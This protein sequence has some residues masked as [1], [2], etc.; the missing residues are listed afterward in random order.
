MCFLRRDVLSLGSQLKIYP[1]FQRTIR[2]FYNFTPVIFW[3]SRSFYT[4]ITFFYSLATFTYK[5]TLPVRFFTFFQ[6]LRYFTSFYIFF[7]RV[8]FFYINIYFYTFEYIF[9]HLYKTKIYFDKLP[10]LFDI[11]FFFV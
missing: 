10:I 5:Y 2:I 6:I 9:L 1:Y 8:T 7:F 4:Q 11:S 3:V